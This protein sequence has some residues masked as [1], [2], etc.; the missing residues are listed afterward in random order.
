MAPRTQQRPR[1]TGR[2]TRSA[3]THRSQRFS[4]PTTTG[5]P[6]MPRRGRGKPQPQSPAQKL[7]GTLGGVA[8]GRQAG[9][10]G[11]MGK[12]AAFAG[13]AGLALKNRDKLPGRGRS[14]TD[15]TYPRDN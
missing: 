9:K 15:T 4:R 8:L 13:L 7:L 11:G 12:F 14:Q 1:T 10:R 5:R 3:A 2:A 6:A